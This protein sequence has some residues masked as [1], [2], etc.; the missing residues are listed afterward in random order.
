M[1]AGEL[2]GAGLWYLP[3]EH[4]GNQNFSPEEVEAVHALVQRLTASG[5]TWIDAKGNEKAADARR[6]PHRRAL[7]R[8][9]LRDRRADPGARVGT[10]D[11]F[12]GQEAA[13]VICSMATSTADDA[14]RGMGFLYSR[15]R[16]NVATSRARCAVIM[17]ASSALFTPGCQTPG[18]MK[19]ANAWCR[20]AELA[21]RA[22][23]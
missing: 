15:N 4:D 18:Q 13:V 5:T 23:R 9:G 20:F 8:A 7:Q 11:R 10:V 1:N 17:V 6:H 3:V 22:H 19:L 21:R 2:S 14:P 16:L 12:Q